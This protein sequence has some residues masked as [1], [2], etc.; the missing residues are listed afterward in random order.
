V[1]AET[2]ELEVRAALREP[3]RALMERE[4][5]VVDALLDDDFTGCDAAGMI[6]GKAQWLT[7][8][9]NG[10]LTFQS[11]DAGSVD[12]EVV[13]DAVRVRAQL[14]FGARYTRSNDNGSFRC[15]AWMSAAATSRS[16]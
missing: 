12:L 6:V 5:S 16:C 2:K 1:N 3:A 4:L 8:L 13:D 15:R 14:T 7:D 9:A 11:I 10:A